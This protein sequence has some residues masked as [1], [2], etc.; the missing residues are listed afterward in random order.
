MDGFRGTRGLEP[1]VRALLLYQIATD[2]QRKELAF[3]DAPGL[4]EGGGRAGGSPR[5]AVK[6]RGMHPQ[7]GGFAG[8]VSEKRSKTF[9]RG[10]LYN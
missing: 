10:S 4:F 1:E 2:L 6:G 7:S 8:N 3:V 5:C 9:A